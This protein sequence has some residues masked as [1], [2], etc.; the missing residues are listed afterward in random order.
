MSFPA[1]M[2]LVGR[3]R[4]VIIADS[5]TATYCTGTLGKALT[6][7]TGFDPKNPP[8]IANAPFFCIHPATHSTGITVPAIAYSLQVYVGIEDSLQSDYQSKG[9]TEMRGLFRI[10]AL[11]TLIYD[12]LEAD[13]DGANLIMNSCERAYTTDAFPLVLAT[14]N[15]TVTLPHTIGI[16]ITL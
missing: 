5:A 3:W 9:A 4:D 13:A 16:D 10:D 8:Q 14:M 11:S 12:A 7:F 6:A 2:S 15:I 1:I